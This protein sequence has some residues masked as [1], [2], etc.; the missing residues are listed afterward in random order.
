MTKNET[1]VS[2]TYDSSGKG[3]K[4][5]T[6]KACNHVKKETYTIAK[7]TRSSSS[8]SGGSGGGGGGSS[9]GGGSSGGGGGGSSW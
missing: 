6:C 9:W 1:L 2:P 8:G 7:L 3:Q 5:Y 4:T